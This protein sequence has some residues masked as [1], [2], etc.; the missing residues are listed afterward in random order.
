M[1][2]MSPTTVTEEYTEDGKIII[3]KTPGDFVV[4][5]LS[6][7]SLARAVTADVLARL[8][9]IQVRML[10]NV[11]DLNTLEVPQARLTNH[12]YRAIGLGTFGW[13]HLLALK[14]IRWESQEAIDY[15][16]EL[17]EKISFLTIHAS[18]ELAKEKG[19]YSAFEGSDWHTGD[20]F[21]NRDYFTEDI[22]GTMWK[23]LAD[24]VSQCGIRNA[25]LMA[26]APNASTAIIAGSTA[27]IDPIYKKFYSEEKKNYKIPVVVPDLNPTTMWLYKS[28]FEIDQMFSI[29]QN[30][31]RQ[32]HI[33]QA[34]SF[35]LY[36]KNTTK[37]KEL[38]AYHL[39]A[40]KLG[41]KS[42]YYTRSTTVDIDECESCAS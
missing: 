5:N 14:G 21:K 16:D 12:K 36:I 38:L 17:Y 25:Y 28:A 31:K 34:I 35:N 9:P 18:M 22:Q 27:S 37:A 4:C 10:D 24:L 40:W 6:S 19:A 13:H 15:A 32:R 7:I 26:V 11:I 29:H 3:T 41:M 20:Y 2:N 33:D 39:E 8:V 1:Q 23:Q 30:A 42:I